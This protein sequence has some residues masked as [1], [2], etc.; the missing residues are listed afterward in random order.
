M[1]RGGIGLALA[2]LLAGCECAQ[3]IDAR[4]A[5]WRVS[6]ADTTIWLIGTI[7]ALP[8]AVRWQTPAIAEVI[9]AA[10]TLVLEVPPAT[11]EAHVQFET[12]ARQPGLPPLSRRVPPSERQKMI[13]GIAAAGLSEPGLQGYKTW[14]AALVIGAASGRKSEASADLGVEPVLSARF[15]GKTIGALETREGQLRLF[16]RL[17]AAAQRRLLVDAATDAVEPARGYGTLLAAWVKGDAAALFKTL[18]TVRGEPTLAQPLIVQRNRRWA[19]EIIRR[20]RRP[21]RVLVAVGAGHL[22][23]PGSVI[24]LMRARGMQVQR[25]E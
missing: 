22:V 1:R 24:D 11:P 8:P 13:R 15:A 6:D 25:I 7:H 18:D 16:D 17:P 2:L 10:D 21:G 20:M 9:A 5:V 23:G 3:P 4:P 12:I 14:G 19:N